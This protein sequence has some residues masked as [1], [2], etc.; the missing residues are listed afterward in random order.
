MKIRIKT[1]CAFENGKI[2][3]G[4]MW[5]L[6]E[7]KFARYHKFLGIGFWGPYHLYWRGLSNENFVS[8]MRFL[9]KRHEVYLYDKVT[10]WYKYEE[11]KPKEGSGSGG[12]KES[13]Q[14]NDGDVPDPVDDSSE[15]GG[16][17]RQ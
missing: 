10:G 16:H 8:I 7:I 14:R 2:D 15:D 11:Q 12:D 3:L 17:H 13:S 5:W 9:K 1:R 6:W 4:D